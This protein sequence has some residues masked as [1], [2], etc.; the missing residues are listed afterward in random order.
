ML[1]T[2]NLHEYTITKLSIVIAKV[3]TSLLSLLQVNLAIIYLAVHQ[4]VRK[5]H[6][7]KH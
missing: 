1:H 2:T 6:V 5:L 3:I 4:Y 7:L